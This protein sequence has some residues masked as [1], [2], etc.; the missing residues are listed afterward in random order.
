QESGSGECLD[1]RIQAALVTSSLVLVD[2]ALVGHA[3]NDRYGGGV[4]SVGLA[5]ALGVER[6]G[7]VLD[8]GTDHGAQAGVMATTL[9]SLFRAFFGRRCIGHRQAP[10]KNWGIWQTNKAANHADPGGPCQ[11]RSPGS[12]RAGKACL[13]PD[14]CFLGEPALHSPASSG[15]CRNGRQSRPMNLLKSLARVSSAT[16]LSRILGFVRDT[17]MARIFGAGVAADAFVVAFKL[18]NLLRRIFAEGAFSQAFVPIL[19]EYKNQR[20]EE[21]ARL[22]L[23]YVAGLLTLVLALVTLV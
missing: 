2:D 21:A 10:R 14:R 5:E 15:K 13:G 11:A 4:G 20:G 7:H 16:M 1:V 12:F 6:L 17:I 3:V 8:V 19:A 23:A 9:L 22:F 18:P